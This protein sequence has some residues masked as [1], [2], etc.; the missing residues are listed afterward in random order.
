MRVGIKVGL[1]IGSV[2]LTLGEMTPPAL[3]TSGGPLKTFRQIL[4]EHNVDLTVPAMLGAL[5]NS[6]IEVVRE[7]AA[8]ELAAEPGAAESI[9]DMAEVLAS[10]KSP[11]VR[12]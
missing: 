4:Q 8:Y 1:V 5:K 11:S 6:Q 3:A 7:A 10:E 2:L 12:I 9:A